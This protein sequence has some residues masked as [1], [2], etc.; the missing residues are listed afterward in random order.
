M[1]GDVR[2]RRSEA[3]LKQREVFMSSGVIGAG[4]AGVQASPKLQMNWV[5]VLFLNLQLRKISILLQK[6]E[7]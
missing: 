1:A 5:A 3:D 2:P 7:I 4:E 6:M